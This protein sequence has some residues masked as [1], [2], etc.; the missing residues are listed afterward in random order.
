M[1]IAGET[2]IMEG[3][4]SRVGANPGSPDV[5]RGFIRRAIE[6]ADLDAV[7]VSLYQLTDD[8]AI[9][10]LPVAKALSPEQR[11]QLV[12]RAVDWLERHASPDMPV[13]P[14]AEKLRELMALTIHRDMSDLE[15]AARRDLAGFRDFPFAVEWKGEKPP[16]PEG[17]R[18]AIIGSG[19]SGLAAAVQCEILGLPYVLLERQA[20]PGGTWTINR[21]P[22]VR[23]DT[24]SIT[25]EFSFEKRYPW[26]EHFGKGAD[27]RAYL[28]HISR[29][30]GVFANTRFCN[31]V[32]CATFNET[33]NKWSLEIATPEGVDTLDVNVVMTAC[34]TFA[35]AKLPDF[36]GIETFRGQVIHPSR[37][38]ADLDLSGKRVALIGNGSTGVQ[39]LG[40]IARE[41][42]QV[43]AIQRTPQWIS[44]REKYGAPM[45]AELTWLINNLPGYWNWW[46]YMATATLFDIHSLQVADPEWQAKGGIINQGNDALREML[47]GYIRQETGGDEEL[48]AKLVPDYAPFSRRP[49]VDNGWYR[50]LTRDNVELVCG[51]VARLVPE[52]LEMED[53]KRVEVDV[54]IAATGFE[55]AKYLLP[56][57]YEGLAGK[58]LHAVWDAGDGPRAYRSMMVPDFPN[59]FMIY[60]PNSQPLSGG[61]GLPAWYLLW[62]SFAGQCI[63]R[64]LREGKSR[65]TVTHRA[66]A[67]YNEAL[68]QEASNLIQ[69]TRE[70]GV[71][72]N[73][74][75]NNT[76]HRLQ[77][78]APWQSPDF[79]R[80]CSVVDWDD[81]ELS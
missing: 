51:S 27:V 53:G 56:A 49:V 8:K 73:Y 62:A 63:M 37:W 31:D 39:M 21:Y 23:V 17:F 28:D 7:R 70:G 22:E 55:V 64:M 4:A 68:D 33:T 40:A 13:E 2:D 24:P 54:I 42:K 14:P 10:M 30:Y 67:D 15:F 52:G 81:L 79:H 71:E 46:R 9:A 44:P 19:P 3:Q 80:M 75:V 18:V 26:K 74:Y 38:P 5:D 50:A 69:L 25:Y 47:T 59:L 11:E 34:G 32:K 43:F 57:R 20:E 45:E 29:K 16:V 65:V 41:A 12:D 48:I 60:G 78:N 58:D 77:V 72:R 61:T 36:E 66:C 76:H 1:A 35:N 6:L